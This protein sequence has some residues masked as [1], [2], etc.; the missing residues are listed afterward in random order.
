VSPFLPPSAGHYWVRLV[1]GGDRQAAYTDGMEW[2]IPG[3]IESL[4]PM[5]VGPQIEPPR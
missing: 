4:D 2:W 1:P 5:E 3:E